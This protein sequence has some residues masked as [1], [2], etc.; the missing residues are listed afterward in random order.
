MIKAFAARHNIEP[1]TQTYDFKDANKAIS[2]LR[3]G[4]IHYR[5]VLKNRQQ[6]L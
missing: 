1:V 4:K 5:I 3:E 2:Q 6:S